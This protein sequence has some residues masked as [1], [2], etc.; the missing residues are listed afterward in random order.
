MGIH[1]IVAVAALIAATAHAQPRGRPLT[2][3]QHMELAIRVCGRVTEALDLPAVGLSG[4]MTVVERGLDQCF[5]RAE[6]RLR[7][8]PPCEYRPG[9]LT[10]LIA[11]RDLISRGLDEREARLA[12][13]RAA[14]ERRRT[15]GRR[16]APATQE[17][18]EAESAE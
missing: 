16:E 6:R 10:C 12:E 1:G 14:R 4:N 15:R 17:P 9:S 5:S 13:R 8:R 18:A 11:R 3:D 2:R 7:L